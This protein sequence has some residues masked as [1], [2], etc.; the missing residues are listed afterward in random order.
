M[1]KRSGT[2]Q[3]DRKGDDTLGTALRGI[4]RSQ[5]MTLRDVSEVARCSDGL[6]SKIENGKTMPSLPTLRRIAGALGV[7]MGE[8]LDVPETREGHVTRRG[9]VTVDMP[10]K[11]GSRTRLTGDLLRLPSGPTAIDACRGGPEV[12]IVVDG[13]VEVRTD[14]VMRRL[15]VGESFPIPVGAGQPVTSVGDVPGTV[16]RMRLDRLTG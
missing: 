12:G 8:V 9:Q 6:L 5:K 4:R 2:V 16:L 11:A 13:E 10:G 1:H 14:E 3:D 7:T 15:K